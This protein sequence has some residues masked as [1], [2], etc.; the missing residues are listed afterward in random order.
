MNDLDVLSEVKKI[1]DEKNATTF[2]VIDVQEATKRIKR[3]EILRI[4]WIVSIS[5]AVSLITVYMM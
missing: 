5:V 1:M 4:L 3:K 2:N